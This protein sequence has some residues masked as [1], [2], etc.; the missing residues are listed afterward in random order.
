MQIAVAILFPSPLFLV[1]LAHAPMP[2]GLQD[3]S[4]PW[5]DLQT[6][7]GEAFAGVRTVL[8]LSTFYGI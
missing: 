6:L 4:G 2:R 5:N 1:L 7:P 8:Q 3:P